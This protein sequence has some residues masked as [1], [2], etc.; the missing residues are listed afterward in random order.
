MKAK[1]IKSII[2]KKVN[3]W[4][5]SIEDEAVRTAVSDKVIVTGGAI[6]S[7][8][9]G[10]KVNDFDVYLTD[11]PA[12]LALAKYYVAKFKEASP[13]KHKDGKVVEMSVEDL[14]DR[15]R[16]T[17]ESQGIAGEG[18]SSGYAYFEGNE[19]SN[20]ES[21]DFVDRAMEKA[22]AQEGEPGK[23]PYRPIFLSANAITLANRIQIVTRFFGPADEIHKNYDFV[24][25]TSHWESET[26]KLMLRPDALEALITRELVYIGSRYP[27][28]SIIRTRKFLTRGFT[29]NAG[30]YLKMI[31]Q[32]HELDLTDIS[33]L[34]EQ[35][36]GVD[37]AYFAHLVEGLRSKMD[38]DPKFKPNYDYIAAIVDRIF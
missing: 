4:L 16:I 7:M 12:L 6:P 11:K 26:G 22:E 31:W 17:I 34:E 2:R 38:N 15:V 5:E 27:L 14:E 19:T 30:Q 21:D 8:L 36:T 20:P 23:K 3:E 1:T 32:V 37:Q 9:L 29:C 10:E 35:L 28:A 25:C 13:Q 33:V 18:E 24:H